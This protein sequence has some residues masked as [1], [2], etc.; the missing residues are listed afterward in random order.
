[1]Q[2]EEFKSSIR[3]AIPLFAF[4]L[5]HFELQQAEFFITLLD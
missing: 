3:R 5:L 2:N 1:M 4:L